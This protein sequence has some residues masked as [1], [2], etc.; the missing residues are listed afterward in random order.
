MQIGKQLLSAWN[1]YLAVVERLFIEA[2]VVFALNR[3]PVLSCN[4]AEKIQLM[5]IGASVDR[6]DLFFG[7]G[8]SMTGS[9]LDQL[10]HII[11]FAFDEDAIQIEDD[12]ADRTL[13]PIGMAESPIALAHARSMPAR[14][15]EGVRDFGNSARSLPMAP[16]PPAQAEG[17]SSH[18]GIPCPHGVSRPVICRDAPH[19][20]ALE[21]E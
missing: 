1:C 7:E 16:A 2:L 4:P 5:L 11:G 21:E 14:L 9:D 13:P 8:L 20:L 12:S 6:V 10:L 15:S 19:L 17:K 18:E 3:S